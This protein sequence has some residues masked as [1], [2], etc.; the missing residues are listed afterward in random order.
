[1]PH[2]N[3]AGQGIPGHEDRVRRRVLCSSGYGRGARL[4][5]MVLLVVVALTS[6][7]AAQDP[8]TADQTPPRSDAGD[9]T[10]APAQNLQEPAQDGGFSG[11]VTAELDRL[12]APRA[13]PVL[14]NLAVQGGWFMIPIAL[15]S[16]IV[17]AFGIERRIALRKGRIIPRRLLQQLMQLNR[18]NNGID[19]REA[20]EVCRRS[21]SPLSRII[22]ATI[23]KVG[24]PQVEVEKTVE[25]AVARESDRMAANLRP[26][27]T[28]ISVAPLLGL[29]GT[30]QGM[31]MAFMV[32]STTT[33]TGS[34]KGAELAQ[35]IYTALVTT[36]AGLCVAI[37]GIVI[38]NLLEARIEKLLRAMEDV[39]NEIVPLFERYEGKWRVVR[40]GDDSG[41]TLK[42]LTPRPETTSAAPT[43][44][45][46]RTERP[47]SEPRER[48][49]PVPIP[50]RDKG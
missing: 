25:D 50:V 40:R 33:A 32:I 31:I 47:A 7:V 20:W 48:K 4:S 42:G 37:P 35:G 45:P 26:I 17:L 6:A 38:V 15:C 44:S 19:P 5:G 24:R 27:S 11:Q 16:V 28:C 36:F 8:G 49:A 21:E 43:A 14:W 46:A 3:T 12:G 39:F 1:M 13:F 23:L 34:A 30:V 9:L 22:Q 29:L 10:V 2:S 18:D 41:V